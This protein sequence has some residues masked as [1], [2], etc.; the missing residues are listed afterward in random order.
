MLDFLKSKFNYSIECTFKEYECKQLNENDVNENAVNEEQIHTVTTI[1]NNMIDNHLF[2]IIY[3]DSM[4][5][6]NDD[7]NADKNADYNEDEYTNN[8]NINMV[9]TQNSNCLSK[10][11][12]LFNEENENQPFNYILSHNDTLL[13]N[14]LI[15]K[16]PIENFIH[17]ITDIC[18]LLQCNEIELSIFYKLFIYL[19]FNEEMKDYKR[20]CFIYPEKYY[21]YYHYNYYNS[22]NDDNVNVNDD[23]DDDDDNVNDDYDK[24]DNNNNDDYRN[25]YFFTPIISIKFDFTKINNK[26]QNQNQNHNHKN[27]FSI[28]KN[29]LSIHIYW[30]I[31][32]LKEIILK[33]YYNKIHIIKSSIHIEC[34][35]FSYH[36]IE[37]ILKEI[38]E[39]KYNDRLYYK[40]ITIENEFYLYFL[41]IPSLKYLNTKSSKNTLS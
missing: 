13:S 21:K 8:I 29:S 9:K 4:I 23:D 19:N 18:T 12:N 5:N 31:P 37:K 17:S 33:S 39:G 16:K 32:V 15:T 24:N 14:P 22:L 35:T 1:F 2:H 38:N 7:K 40:N 3:F 28:I 36:E 34:K 11:H 25:Q 41:Q 26:N 10:N 20:H 30:K 27:I 6:L